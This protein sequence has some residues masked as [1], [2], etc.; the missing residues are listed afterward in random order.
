[1]SPE[2]RTV[3]VLFAIAVVAAA[4]AWLRRRRSSGAPAGVNVVGYHAATSGLGERARELVACLRA[5][6]V[7][8][9]V[10][11]VDGCLLDGPV[12]EHTI[13]V[14]TAI[15][16]AS[17]RE[18]CPAA[19]DHPGRTIG[20]FFWELAEVPADQQ[21]GIGLVDEVWAPTEFVR[22]AYA[23]ATE[24]PVR[25]VPLP[26]AEPDRA[27]GDGS[28]AD[29]FTFLTSFDHRS[30]MERKHPIGAIEAFRRAFPGEESGVR[31]VVKTING[32]ERPAA[33]TRLR[34]AIGDDARIELRDE[35][36]PAAD[37]L[38][39]LAGA[40][41]F[42]SLHRSEGLGLHLAEAMWLGT[43]VLAT[44]YSGNLDVMDDACAAL[45]DAELIPVR[46]T[47]G[48]YQGTAVWA[49]PDLDQAAALMRRLVDDA[50]WRE[51]LIEAAR[52]RMVSQPGRADTGRRIATLLAR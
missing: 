38:R 39:L 48:A 6:G 41:A 24:R 12:R 43:P 5:G 37:H 14:V 40:D 42:V 30:V 3:M 52:T 50:S 25:L 45:V 19:F 15:Q 26:I 1:V 2:L 51:S 34:D 44:R 16:L 36:L 4:I 49:D 11:D 29:A 47:D 21:W 18:T 9:T 33:V 28:P 13:A 10:C 31:L 23:A 27:G 17:V 7:D 22:A 8:V 20:Y 46:D 35:R 32:S